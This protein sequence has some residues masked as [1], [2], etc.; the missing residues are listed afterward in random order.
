MA[1]SSPSVMAR[2]L[3]TSRLRLAFAS[4]QLQGVFIAE[5]PGAITVLGHSQSL[6][7]CSSCGADQSWAKS[8]P[9]G[10]GVQE[11]LEC[12]RAELNT[13]TELVPN[14]NATVKRENGTRR[15]IGY[16]LQ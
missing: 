8:K 13:N 11:V 4:G 12:T 1:T 5:S 16:S 2:A 6:Y 10:S 14:P 7:Y 3:P 15:V 9:D